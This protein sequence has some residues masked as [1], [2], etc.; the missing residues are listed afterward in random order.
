V[1][2]CIVDDHEIV[3]EGLRRAF[4]D[5][6]SIEIVSEAGS[7]FQAIREAKLTLPDLMLVDFRL[8]DMTGDVLCKRIRKGFPS[9]QVVMLTTYL[10]EE[11]V[12]RSIDAGASGFV[13]KASGLRELREVIAKLATG[14][15]QTFDGGASTIVQRLYATDARAAPERSLTPQQERVLELSVQGLTYAEVGEQ[16]HISESTVRFHIHNLKERL[17]VRTKAELIAVAI[18]SALITPDGDHPGA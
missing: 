8:P 17:Q 2:I 5:D 14:E 1:K 7:G 9:T 3:R 4:A 18:R 11:V 12:Q 13:T 15:Q 16:L 10:S 6:S